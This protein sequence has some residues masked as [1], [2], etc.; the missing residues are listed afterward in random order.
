V[1]DLDGH[2][3]V[4]LEILGEEDV[5]IPPRPISRSIR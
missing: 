3:A 4:V 1:Q 2:R 5:A